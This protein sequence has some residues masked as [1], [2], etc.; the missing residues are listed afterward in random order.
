MLHDYIFYRCYYSKRNAAVVV[1]SHP[2]LT[3][4]LNIFYYKTLKR[5][6]RLKISLLLSLYTGVGNFPET[7]ITPRI[8]FREQ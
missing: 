7:K 4:I 5:V 3:P 6:S 2:S 8:Y 1:V